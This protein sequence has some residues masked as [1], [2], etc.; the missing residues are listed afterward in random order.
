MTKT[1]QGVAPGVGTATREYGIQPAAA[2]PL[3]PSTAAQVGSV[4]TGG[5]A[6]I[7]EIA[8]P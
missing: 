5:A 4:L 8:K 6:L 3:A 2:Q 7:K 1:M